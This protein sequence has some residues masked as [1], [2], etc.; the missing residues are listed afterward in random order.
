MSS[1]SPNPSAF[2]LAHLS[3]TWAR[4]A[5]DFLRLFYSRYP[6][7][8][9]IQLTDTTGPTYGADMEAAYS[10]MRRMGESIKQAFPDCLYCVIAC[11]TMHLHKKRFER[12][13][14]LR[15]LD[16]VEAVME[17]VRRDWAVDAGEQ[18]LEGE[19]KK[20]RVGVVGTLQTMADLYE[21]GKDEMLV[22][23]VPPMDVQK[24]FKKFSFRDIFGGRRTCSQFGM[25]YYSLRR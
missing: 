15:M 22:K 23:V 16:M 8:K 21:F 25:C 9:L 17:K 10:I 24:V 5:H 20:T 2:R 12:D 13:T 19:R 1:S 7:A 18:K 11:N 6:T 4:V 3:G 14:G